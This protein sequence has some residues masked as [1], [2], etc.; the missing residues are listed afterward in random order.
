M[1]SF[2][3]RDGRAIVDQRCQCGHAQSLH[4]PRLAE[5]PSVL[6]G[7]F[8]HGPCLEG[9]C[10]CQRFSFKEFIYQEETT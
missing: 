6:V 7:V 9:E 3:T 1:H 5:L 4:G 10:P 2:R 8:R